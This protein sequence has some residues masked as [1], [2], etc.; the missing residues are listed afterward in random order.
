VNVFGNLVGK[1]TPA[2]RDRRLPG[3]GLVR[4]YTGLRVGRDGRLVRRDAMY[5]P[6]TDVAAE[7]VTEV[8]TGEVLVD[9][10]E[11]LREKYE[12]EGRWKPRDGE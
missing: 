3:R 7:K 2:K 12:R 5:D 8:E 1:A 4:F 10:C 9:K 6:Y 11:S